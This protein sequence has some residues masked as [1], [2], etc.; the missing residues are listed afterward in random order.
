MDM[1][2]SSDTKT[3]TCGGCRMQILNCECDEFVPA[4]SAPVPSDPHLRECS[5]CRMTMLNC[6]CD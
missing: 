1:T 3:T 4:M 6:E 5:D 2:Q